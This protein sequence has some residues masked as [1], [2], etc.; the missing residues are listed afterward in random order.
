ERRPA[1]RPAPPRLPVPADPARRGGVGARRGAA[2]RSRPR[3]HGD[4]R[5]ADADHHHHRP[6]ARPTTGRA[7]RGRQPRGAGRG[8]AGSRDAAAAL[9]ADPVAPRARA[10]GRRLRRH[11]GGVHRRRAAARPP[12]GHGAAARHPR[13]PAVVRPAAST[14]DVGRA[15]RGGGE[16]PADHGRDGDGAAH[17][18]GDRWG[19][20]CHGPRR[21]HDDRAGRHD[22]HD[23]AARRHGARGDGDGRDG[24]GR[25]GGHDRDDG[26]DRDHA[27]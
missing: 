19:D 1:L 9:G 10:G 7:R 8:R 3:R 24:A 11:G 12:G 15:R 14:G 4:R 22:R 27:V 2:L 5:G 13:D 18:R 20:D 6:G 26:H 16:R 25:P 17:D 21:R 23:D